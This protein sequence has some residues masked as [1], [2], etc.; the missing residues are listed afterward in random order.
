[1]NTLIIGGNSRIAGHLAE[2]LKKDNHD[3]TLTSRRETLP[4]DDWSWMHF[5]ALEPHLPPGQW[6][7]IYI[8][9]AITGFGGCEKNPGDSWRINADMPTQIVLQAKTVPFK[10]P[11][12]IFTSS[13]AVEFASSTAYGR[14]KMYAECNM[15]AAG[16]CV[17]R[18]GFVGDR[19]DECVDFLT[20]RCDRPGLYRWS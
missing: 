11:H 3:V 5:N 14:Q 12:V 2:R 10:T 13:D 9:A 8:V 20:Q 15:L 17:A 18:L 7:T 6:D 1:M 19:V 16:G 4:A